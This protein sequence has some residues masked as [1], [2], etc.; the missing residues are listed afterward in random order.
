MTY[1]ALLVVESNRLD[2][3]PKYIGVKHMMTFEKMIYSFANELIEG[4]SGGYWEFYEIPRGMFMTLKTDKK[5]TVN[6]PNGSSYEL[7]GFEAGI[8]VCMFAFSNFAFYLYE[9]H[10]NSD[11]MAKYS[12]ALKDYFSGLPGASKI[13]K[14]ID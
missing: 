2:F 10:E 1:D 13:W 5:L 8:V 14:L 12:Y 4:Y 3:L 11:D 9:R 7:T 6:S